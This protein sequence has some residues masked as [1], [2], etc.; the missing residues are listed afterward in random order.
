M[1]QLV[2]NNQVVV[3][4]VNAGRSAFPNA[5]EQAMALFPDSVRRLITGRSS[6]EEA[7]ALIQKRGGIKEVMRLSTWP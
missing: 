6:L 4:T 2:L 3:G 5:L 1:R 7:P